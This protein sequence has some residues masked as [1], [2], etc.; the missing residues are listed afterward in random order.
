MALIQCDF[1]SEA[2]AMSTSMTVILPEVRG[3]GAGVPE[4]GW[5]TLWLL[6]GRS[7]DHTAWTRKTAIERYVEGKNL[8]VVMPMGA[9]SYYADMAYGQRYWT[10]IS[11]ELPRVC[12]G[13]FRLSARREDNFA[14]GLSM[15]GYG[16]FKLALNAPERYAAAASLSGALDPAYLYDVSIGVDREWETIFGDPGEIGGTPSDLMG[17]AAD[18]AAG[19]YKDLP[20]YACCG[21]ADFIYDCSTRFRDH[22]QALG[23]NLTYEEHDGRD[24]EWGYWDQQIQRVLEWLP[25]PADV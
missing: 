6:H 24:H 22:A 14:A 15:G 12:R 13:L 9:R 4:H 19:E 3:E 2:L 7:D 8:A 1:Y 16:A 17:R 23:L 20:L 21:T 5:P 11:E 25:L 18:L 10:M